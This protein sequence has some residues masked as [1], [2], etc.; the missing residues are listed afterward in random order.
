METETKQ[1]AHCLIEEPNQSRAPQLSN[2]HF[3]TTAF[4]RMRSS[5]KRCV[6]L[7]WDPD[8]SDAEQK[9]QPS[10]QRS[11]PSSPPPPPADWDPRESSQIRNPRFAPTRKPE[12]PP[13][14]ILLPSS[15]EEMKHLPLD[16]QRQPSEG[17]KQIPLEEE[18]QDSPDHDS[19]LPPKDKLQHTPKAQT[20]HPAVEGVHNWSQAQTQQL[21][22]S[23]L[24]H[25]PKDPLDEIPRAHDSEAGVSTEGALTPLRPV[26][27]E[28]RGPA[29]EDF[30]SD[31]LPDLSLSFTSRQ[32]V[33]RWISDVLDGCSPNEQ[34]HWTIV[35]QFWADATANDIATAALIIVVKL[36]QRVARDRVY[37]GAS[38]PP[39]ILSMLFCGESCASKA[40]K[41][42][43]GTHFPC[44]QR[45]PT[46]V[47][48][49]LFAPVR[50]KINPVD[51]PYKAIRIFF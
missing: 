46:S 4:F 16:D 49:G 30:G 11:V 31:S 12:Q 7:P 8:S 17:S 20:Q 44:W 6:T 45:Q 23:E 37:E 9:T 40:V 18:V 15:I 42:D 35:K 14:P 22:Q 13:P 47:D 32:A 41:V 2:S 43:L 21:P 24:R 25:P 50:A 3:A 36:L 29:T 51:E 27:A 39:A 48:W 28:S 33:D 10:S 1:C 38:V 26:Q 19:G 34:F 5:K